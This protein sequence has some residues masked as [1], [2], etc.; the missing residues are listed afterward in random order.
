MTI[1]RRYRTLRYSRPCSL[2]APRVDANREQSWAPK[3]DKSDK[4]DT[5]LADGAEPTQARPFTDSPTDIRK[6]FA[7]ASE[8]AAFRPA[9]LTVDQYLW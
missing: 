4:V 2:T 6:M 7:A 9:S 3:H 5:P 1:C 8:I